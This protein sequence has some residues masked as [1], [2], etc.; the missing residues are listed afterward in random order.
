MK[1]GKWLFKASP[2]VK[3]G[4]AQWSFF[5]RAQGLCLTL[6]ILILG[7]SRWTLDSD[8]Q[9]QVA[10][11]PVSGFLRVLLVD[12]LDQSADPLDQSVDLLDQHGWDLLGLKEQLISAEV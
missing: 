1:P 3:G 9:A 2:A 6:C 8:G 11:R 5:H 12:P 4:C 10:E 7:R